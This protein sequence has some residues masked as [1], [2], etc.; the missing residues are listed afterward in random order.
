MLDKKDLVDDSR[1][2]RLKNRGSM[3]SNYMNI[4]LNQSGRNSD[5]KNY[6]IHTSAIKYDK[7]KQK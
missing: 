2:K 4:Y 1:S 3:T 6:Q 7:L 5:N